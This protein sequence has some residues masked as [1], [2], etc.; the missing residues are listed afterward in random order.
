MPDY[1]DMLYVAQE[2]R[3]VNA[4]SVANIDNF[5]ALIEPIAGKL[6]LKSTPGFSSEERQRVYAAISSYLSRAFN[7]LAIRYHLQQYCSTIE[8][9]REALLRLICP[10]SHSACSEVIRQ[11]DQEGFPVEG[12]G[13]HAEDIES[14]LFSAKPGERSLYDWIVNK[15]NYA[16]PDLSY[17]HKNWI[18]QETLKDFIKAI[19]SNRFRGKYGPASA[20]SYLW[21]SRAITRHKKEKLGIIQTKISE[22][23]QWKSIELHYVAHD[24]H[25]TE[26]N[27]G[28][29]LEYSDATGLAEIEAAMFQE[30]YQSLTHHL[31]SDDEY[32]DDDFAPSESKQYTGTKSIPSEP[33]FDGWGDSY[34]GEDPGWSLE[35]RHLRAILRRVPKWQDLE[36]KISEGFGY[37]EMREI[38]GKREFRKM[39]GPRPK[40]LLHG[41]TQIV[42]TKITTGKFVYLGRY[43]RAR[44]ALKDAV[45]SSKTGY[46]DEGIPIRGY[47]PVASIKSKRD[48]NDRVPNMLDCEAGYYIGLK[49]ELDP[50]E[51]DYHIPPAD[52]AKRSY[53]YKTYNRIYKKHLKILNRV[54]KIQQHQSETWGVCVRCGYPHIRNEL[55]AFTHRDLTYCPDC[56]FTVILPIR[57]SLDLATEKYVMESRSQN[58]VL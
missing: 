49:E 19:R 55:V 35:R 56:L 43:K 32:N 50:S 41:L 4:N 51:I 10:I 11:K 44:L 57:L 30:E 22:F 46:L 18:L 34:R 38:F 21:A 36:F 48:F 28:D 8:E 58:P 52:R 53:Q 54:R 2:P 24:V 12:Q 39:P 14:L 29:P 40:N 7:D 47:V 31:E 25:V 9:L 33:P 6:V 16:V 42:I 23:F 37:E 1:P 27:W 13:D 5:A 45:L 3:V 17:H 15:I 20:K 26:S